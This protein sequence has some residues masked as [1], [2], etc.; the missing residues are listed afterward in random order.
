MWRG[1]KV[2]AHTVAVAESLNS[3]QQFIDALKKLKPECN[4]TKLVTTSCEWRKAG[5]K[6]GAPRKQGSDLH[7]VPITAYRSRLDDICS[8]NHDTSTEA[9]A[10]TS[11]VGGTSGYGQQSSN[12]SSISGDITVGCT[13]Q[14]FYFNCSPQYRSDYHNFPSSP[15]YGSEFFYPS[16]TYRYSE[17]Q[18]MY[19]YNYNPYGSQF[20][21]P[22]QVLSSPHSE[23][24]P[25]VVKLLNNHIKKCRGCNREFSRKVDGSPWDPPL[26]LVM[27]HEERRP[28]RDASNATRLSH[29]Q[30]VYYHANLSCIRANNPSFIGHE[31]EILTDV[32]LSSAHCK[33]LREHFGCEC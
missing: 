31:V 27:Y 30:N 10:T 21:S 9:R 22:P 1:R 23:S 33:Y 17:A 20:Q 32:E 11:A 12:E 6:S 5:M 26:N 7:K 3:L 16:S 29:P 13:S 15:W 19:G 14:T 2:C 8:F 4:V 28:Y 25:F 24:N 18:G